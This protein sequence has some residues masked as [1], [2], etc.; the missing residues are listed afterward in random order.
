MCKIDEHYGF[1]TEHEK[2]HLDSRCLACMAGIKGE[3]KGKNEHPKRLS[4]TE[5][6]ACKDAIAFFIPPS[7]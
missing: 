6:D 4:M 1:W 5:G 2:K 7:N 3:A